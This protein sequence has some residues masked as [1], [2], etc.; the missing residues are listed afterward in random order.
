[1]KSVKT[2]N[3]LLFIINP[4]LIILGVT[5]FFYA[6]A[7]II[8]SF[9]LFWIVT[10]C[11]L[12]LVVSSGGSHR[13][14]HD[15]SHRANRVPFAIWIFYIVIIEAG[16]YGIYAG[17]SAV[18]GALIPINRSVDTHLFSESVKT[19]LLHF[20]LFPWCIYAVIAV[21]MGF[22]AYNKQTDAYFSYLIKPLTKQDPHQT[23][24]FL[25]NVGAKRATQFGLSVTMLFMTL[26]CISFALPL[27]IP[28]STGFQMGALLTTLIVFSLGYSKIANKY[29]KRIFAKH[30]PTFF[31]FPF[32]A[33]LIGMLIVVIN[34]LITPITQNNPAPSMP[35]IITHWV[36]YNTNTAWLIFSVLWWISLAP[37]VSGLITRISVGYKIKHIIL[38]VLALPVLIL[39]GFILSAQYHFLLPA[40][41]L[42]TT[43]LLSLGAFLMI[44]P[45]L[46][47]HRNAPTVIFSY[48]PKNG[49]LKERD[50]QPF[51]LSVV[52]FIVVCFY[53]ML[54]IGINGLSAFVFTFLYP[55]CLL[56]LIAALA[57]VVVLM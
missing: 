13:L 10:A 6:G 35:E 45:A 51:F 52:K 54:A 32:F 15:E 14:M 37:M 2:S 53:F 31:G 48:F 23:L 43:Q 36:H 55:V 1:M 44:L 27:K 22:L 21:G 7:S 24:G 29:I 34:I 42:F 17:I 26:L 25:A 56:I 39:A 11:A 9:Y 46:L 47:N 30:I 12:W 40:P 19:L 5:L 50:R 49:L 4:L 20:G 33:V 38:G 41:S 3:S 28:F 16:L 57:I 8:H 18:V